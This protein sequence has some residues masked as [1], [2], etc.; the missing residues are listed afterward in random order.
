MVCVPMRAQGS[1]I[2]ILQAIDPRNKAVFDADDGEFFQAFRQLCRDRHPERPPAQGAAHP[3]KRTAGNLSSPARSRKAFCRKR[4]RSSKASASPVITNRR[5]KSAEIFTTSSSFRPPKVGPRRGDVTGKASPLRSTWCAAFS[6]RGAWPRWS[7]TSEVLNEI[8]VRLAAEADAAS[9]R[10]RRG[11]TRRPPI[12]LGLLYATFDI[13]TRE[14]RY[15]NADLPPPIL[16]GADRRETLNESGGPAIGMLPGLLYTE[17]VTTL[18][19]GETLLFY[20]DG[21]NEA[22]NLVGLNSATSASANHLL[23]R[24][25]TRRSRENNRSRRE[26]LHGSAAATTTLPSWRCTSRLRQTL[27]APVK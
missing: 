21:L 5:V 3:A 13:T 19:G 18:T 26:P 20:T 17:G 2:G 6:K 11:R 25:T 7:L 23:N 4:F 22:R 24:T 8:N 27:T 9:R 15:A 10:M 12:F 14:L 1:V 16:H